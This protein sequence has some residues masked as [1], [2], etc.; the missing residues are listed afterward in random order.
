V[1]SSAAALRPIPQSGAAALDSL[2]AARR[3]N[4]VAQVDLF[5][6]FYKT[7]VTALFS[8][9]A[10]Y[11]AAGYFGDDPIRGSALETVRDRGPALIGVVIAVAVAI[12][13]RS[14][15]RGGPLALEQADVRH[16]L[17]APIDRKDSVRGPALRQLRHGAF[18]GAV[19][20]A[21][22]GLI[23]LRRLPGLPVWW[24]LCGGLVGAAAITLSFG[25]AM[26]A[27]GKRLSR[28]VTDT[29]AFLVVAWAAADALSQMET[30]PASWLGHVVTWPLGFDPLGVVG[31]LLA[32]ASGFFGLVSISGWSTEAAERRSRLVGQLRFAATLQDVRTVM[33]IQRQLAQEHLRSRP[34]VRIRLPGRAVKKGEPTTRVF[35]NRSLNGLL[36]WPF[37]RLLRLIVL[38]LLAGFA[39]CGAWLGTTPL[40]VVSG[41]CLWLAG[42]D[43]LEPLAQ[44]TDRPDRMH[45]V[46]RPPGRGRARLLIVPGL[47]LFV[48]V[49]IGSVPAVVLGDPLV[50]GALMPSIVLS[51]TMLALGGASLAVTAQPAPAG[52]SV[53][54]PEAA[55]ALML[56]RLAL[57]PALAVLGLAPV[58]VARQSWLNHHNGT[59]MLADM[60]RLW[61][62]ALVFGSWAVAWI[63]YG[64]EMRD[65]LGLAGARAVRG[66][67]ALKK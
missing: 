65:Q 27:S 4:Q 47:G 13:L 16:L 40:I 26:I 1:S 59:I 23:G 45:G 21:A 10:V 55:G 3:R 17:L 33:V 48:L 62:I 6:A 51:A 57:P 20:G 34:L 15:G 63:R 64:E 38:A 54:I 52:S 49:L 22:I 36:R 12:G 7:Y 30:S 37:F 19:I 2:R 60:N 35:V 44:E 58:A 11:S 25:V 32:A 39:L 8:S 9:I 56:L 61:L 18:L 53:Q 29:L 43:L 5:D 42:L 67:E 28:P 14:G 31:C 66:P 41:L 24:V 46:G 50:V